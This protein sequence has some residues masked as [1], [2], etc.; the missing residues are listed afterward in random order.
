MSAVAPAEPVMIPA[1]RGQ[2]VLAALGAVAGLAGL[3]SVAGAFASRELTRQF[4]FSYLTGFAF[5][6]SLGVGAL[7]WVMVHHLVGAGWSVVVRRLFEGLARIATVV[8]LLFLPVALVLGSLY[9]WASES[10]PDALLLAKRP[11]LNAPFFY[12]RALVYTVA[13]TA[14]A[15]YF[16]R[17]SARQDQDGDPD[18]TR[19]MQAAS[20]PGMI[21]LALTTTFAAFDWLMSLDYKWYSTIFGVYFWAGSILGSLATL[22]LVVLGF[23]AAGWLRLT[24]TVEHLHDLGK[25]MIGFTVFWA[26]IAFSQ[27]FLIWYANIPEET[28][29]YL[30]RRVPGWN[31]VS[32]ALPIG[33]FLV[34][35]AVLLPRANKRNPVVMAFVAAWLLAF[36]YLDLYWQVMPNLH[37]QG[38]R[39]H[40]LDLTA[41]VAL[42]C[43][44]A[45]V[46]GRAILAHPLIPVRD[47]RLE[48]SLLFRN[49]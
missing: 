28:A 34:P 12:V 46:V 43:A 9:L 40:W 1:G 5:V 32:W 8:L 48:E 13:W 30:H 36:H 24:I 23:R 2:A 10:R 26:Y 27:Y 18:H 4:A 39:P 37:E 41:L 29:F 3:V 22:V 44:C 16:T 19:R 15:I 6:T 35:F 47:P 33:H 42:V 49:F 7:F 17:Q 25:L 45:F 11:F 14:L 38:V 31:P 20:G 21:V